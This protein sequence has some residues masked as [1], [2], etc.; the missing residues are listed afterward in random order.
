[1]TNKLTQRIS[2]A[3]LD[4]TLPPGGRRLIA[5][6][7]FKGRTN[8]TLVRWLEADEETATRLLMVQ[9][10][11]VQHEPPLRITRRSRKSDGT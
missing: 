3:R 10:P 6:G 1:M 11:T 5:T 9:Y 4:F 7:D 2:Q 8:D